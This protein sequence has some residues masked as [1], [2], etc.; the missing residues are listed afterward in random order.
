MGG[1]PHGDRDAAPATDTSVTDGGTELPPSKREYD[2]DDV[3]IR[4]GQSSRPRTR[5]RP[6]HD[7]AV[8]ALVITVDRGRY[9]CVR[10]DG[11]DEP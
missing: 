8:D 1:R 10:E 9:G 4:P 6:K 5:T 3:R 11:A 2:E 7:D